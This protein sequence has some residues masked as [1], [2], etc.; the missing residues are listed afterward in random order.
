MRTHYLD[1]GLLYRLRRFALRFFR[2]EN[3]H[4]TIMFAIGMLFTASLVFFVIAVGK[5]YLQKETVQAAADSAAF[6]AAAAEAKV[7]NT[8]SFINIVLSIGVAMVYT[9]HAI[10]GGITAFVAEVGGG[11]V[12]TAGVE[13]LFAEDVCAF[14]AGPGEILAAK[15]EKAAEDLTERL[16]PL[17]R[18]GE[19]VARLGPAYIALEATEAGMH[20]AYKKREPGLLAVLKPPIERLPVQPGPANT[21]CGNALIQAATGAVVFGEGL[22]R[23]PPEL[24]PDVRAGVAVN[25]TA[26]EVAS[27]LIVCEAGTTGLVPQELTP[28][29]PKQ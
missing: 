26:A 1:F 22:L 28:D 11:A 24:T 16:R 21:V 27:A 13:C 19:Q 3:G 4:I 5:R 14:A 18:A 17:A 20:D 29:W 9:L 6:A 23:L 25:A 10:F 12:L 8:L 15:Y 7:F 2:N